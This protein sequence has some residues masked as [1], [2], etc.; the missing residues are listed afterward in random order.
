M[1][2]AKPVRTDE[3]R[4]PIVCRRLVDVDVGVSYQPADDLGV[5]LERS[6][7]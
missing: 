7:A 1:L 2:V 6:P 4:D 3:G 5:A